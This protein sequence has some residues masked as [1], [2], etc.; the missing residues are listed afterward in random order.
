MTIVRE[1]V[2]AICENCGKVFQTKYGFFC[3][4]CLKKQKSKRAKSIG[5]NKIGNE[6]YSNQQAEL[7]SKRNGR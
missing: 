5:L 6:A 2:P 4:D 7:K 3:P 1:T